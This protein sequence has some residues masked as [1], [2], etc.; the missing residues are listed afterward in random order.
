MKSRPVIVSACLAGLSTRHDGSNALNPGL[1]KS[2]EG[3]III[4][5]CPE[6]LGG[7]RTPRPR[8]EI[9][10]GDGNDV[11]SGKASVLDEHGKDV[12]TSFTKGAG[13]VLKIARLCG[14][15]EA[16]LKENSPA[17]GVKIICRKGACA[18]GM[19]VTAALLEREGTIKIS[20]A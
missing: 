13:E 11:L 4:P 3:R 18:E 19:G 1:L 14:A 20:G 15:T 16:V 10:N 12:T 8:S 7:L 2:L 6:Q 17:C 5:V 9:T